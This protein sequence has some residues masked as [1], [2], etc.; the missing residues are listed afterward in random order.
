MST[1]SKMY[2]KSPRLE[3]DAETEKLKVSARPDED[4]GEGM[5]QE[6]SPEGIP[7]HIRHAIER[8]DVHS[9]HENEHMVHDHGRADKAEVHK[10]HQEEIKTMHK[11]HEKEMTGSHKKAESGKEEMKK[12]KTEKEE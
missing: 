10:R 12:V 3:R 1:A 5:Q 7:T 11:R 9:R 2:K 8:R 4:K 6:G